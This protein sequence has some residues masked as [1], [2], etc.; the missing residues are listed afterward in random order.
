MS[1]VL[2]VCGFVAA[3]AGSWRAFGA[4]RQAL[5]PLVHDGDPTR[6][7]V[8]A[9]RPFVTRYRVRLF[10]RRVVVSIGWLIVSLYGLYLV[11]VGSA[12]P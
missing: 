12:A 8:E 4:V 3:F 5:G 2:I 10:A 6:T 7:A 1:T 11:A 9:A